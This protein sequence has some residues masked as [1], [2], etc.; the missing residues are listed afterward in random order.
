M[1]EEYRTDGFTFFASYYNGAKFLAPE[2]RTKFFLAILDYAFE[3]IEPKFDSTQLSMAW[4]LTVPT[5]DSGITSRKYGKMGGRKRKAKDEGLNEKP[6]LNAAF[7]TGDSTPPFEPPF[8]RVES[9]VPDNPN[10]EKRKRNE[11][12]VRNIAPTAADSR[13]DS[14]L[15]KIVQHYQ[16]TVGDFPRSALDKLQKWRQVFPADVLCAAFDEAAENG[17]R[18]WRY[19]DGILTSWQADGVRTLGDVEGRRESRNKPKG[20]QEQRWEVLE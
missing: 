5:I 3:G 1:G 16:Q 15:A 6:A 14:E 19:I 7:E 11:V 13:T 12:E 17:H 2:E 9:N 8:Q 4:A 10:E 18:S 20:Q